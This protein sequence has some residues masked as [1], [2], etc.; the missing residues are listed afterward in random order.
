L[1]KYLVFVESKAKKQ[2]KK[3]PKEHQTRI[4]VALKTLEDEGFST[5]LDIKKLQGY[6][7]HYRLRVGKTIRIRFE[8]STEHR[9]IVYSISTREKAY[10]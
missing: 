2:F 8:L 1:P 3:M 7:T 5:R 4:L 6:K 10:E 9:L